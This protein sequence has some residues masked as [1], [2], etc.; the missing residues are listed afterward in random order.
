MKPD[1]K[2]SPSWARYLAQDYAG[3]WYWYDNYPIARTSEWLSKGKCCRAIA[4]NPNWRK[5]L[6]ERPVEAEERKE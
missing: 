3:T 4:P 6:E 1:W 2:D 5:T